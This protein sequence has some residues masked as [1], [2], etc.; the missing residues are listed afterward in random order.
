VVASDD[1]SNSSEL[2]K[3]MSKEKKKQSQKTTTLSIELVDIGTLLDE[4]SEELANLF[5][6]QI[7]ITKDS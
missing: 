2:A 3:T 4:V 7:E 6:R 1:F 5:L